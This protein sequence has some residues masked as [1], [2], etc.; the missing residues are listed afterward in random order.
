MGREEVLPR[1]RH[2]PIAKGEITLSG[3]AAEQG[4]TGYRF[5]SAQ[6]TYDAEGGSL[7][8]S[9]DGAI[10]FTGHGGSLDL[11]FS[12]LGI[13]VDGA[14]GALMA[15]VSAK[16]RDTG[17]VTESDDVRVA[18]LTTGALDPKGDV[19]TLT[20]APAAPRADGAK[21]FGGFYAAGDALDPVTVA[22]SLDEDATLPDGSPSGGTTGG[23]TTGGGT[24]G[25]TGS[26]ATTGADIPAREM[27]GGAAALGAVGAATVLAATRR[28]GEN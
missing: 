15:D 23:S 26:L 1:L 28:R 2:R 6:G 21:A 20:D 4:T 14:K 8:A 16:D 13:E 27:L 12:D 5:P 25:G 10:R 11:K 19:I 9:F 7:D 24:T 3:G 22:V 17:K 18:D